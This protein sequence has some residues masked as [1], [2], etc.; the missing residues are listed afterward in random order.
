MLSVFGTVD[1]LTTEEH[2]SVYFFGWCCFVQIVAS[3]KLNTQ[4]TLLFWTCHPL[5]LVSRSFLMAKMMTTC[6]NT[7]H[8]SCVLQSAFMWGRDECEGTSSAQREHCQNYVLCHLWNYDM[9][10][11]KHNL[12]NTYTFYQKISMLLG[13]QKKKPKNKKKRSNRGRHKMTYFFFQRQSQ[14]HF[15]EE[16]KK[17]CSNKKK[18]YSTCKHK[19]NCV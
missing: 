15:Q 3:P 18:S 7:L 16:Y 4:F 2:L 17:S 10:P 14:N 19:T 8:T 9:Y 12:D 13:K 5:P 1:R 6:T 11:F